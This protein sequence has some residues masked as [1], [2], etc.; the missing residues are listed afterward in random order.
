M[1]LKHA[2]FISYC[3]G[4]EQLTRIF[5]EQLRDSL[6]SSLEPLMDQQVYIDQERLKPG[7]KFNESLALALCQSV[8]MI[9]VYSPKYERHAYCLREFHAMKEIEAKR[10]SILKSHFPR[11]Y[12]LIIPIIFRGS[13]NR[14]PPSLRHSTHY[15]N[16]SK[17]TT[18]SLEISRNPEYVAEIEK[19]AA[20]IEDLYSLFEDSQDE[21]SR[22][23]NDF[24]LPN[25]DDIQDLLVPYDRLKPPFP[26]RETL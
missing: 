10:R 14:I 5:I 21:I 12:S 6:K 25:E 2:C 15:C 8:S 11:E 18:A 22:F 24:L 13:E 7:F 17:F 19:I 4:R 23:C 1:P 16:F 9:L 26:G 20:F 3:H